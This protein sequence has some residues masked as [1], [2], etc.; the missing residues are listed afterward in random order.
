MNNLLFLGTIS[1]FDSYE[2][3]SRQ[4][5]TQRW[6]TSCENRLDQDLLHLKSSIRGLLYRLSVS[7]HEYPADVYSPIRSQVQNI[8]GM[9]YWMLGS[10]VIS[11]YKLLELLI[12]KSSA[13]D[14]Y[15]SS[16]YKAFK[17][18]FMSFLMLPR[19]TSLQRLQIVVGS[20]RFWR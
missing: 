4:S 11:S 5:F 19:F 3:R 9:S 7:G 18:L 6:N 8:G 13:S 16:L 14:V 20:T 2:S 12:R 1:R 15:Q 10:I 17:D